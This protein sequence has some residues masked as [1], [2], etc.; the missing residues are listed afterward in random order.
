MAIY[1]GNGY[2]DDAPGLVSE[3]WCLNYGCYAYVLMDSYG[4]GLSNNGSCATGDG[5]LFISQ[6]GDSLTSVPTSGADFGDQITLNFCLTGA[7]LN[8]LDDNN[9]VLYP[10][11]S[12]GVVMISLEHPT[13]G[14][15]QVL[16]LTGQLIETYGFNGQQFKMNLTSLSAGTYLVRFMEQN[17]KSTIKKLILN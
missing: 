16:T 1:A 13:S 14:V 10:N 17:G 11:P 4:D 2:A 5:N 12:N 6:A 15:F 7:G 3:S 8:D 9:L